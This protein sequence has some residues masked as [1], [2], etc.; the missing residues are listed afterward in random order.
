MTIFTFPADE[1]QY[2][3]Q[4]ARH[5]AYAGV[6]MPSW[7]CPCCNQPRRTAGRKRRVPISPRGGFICA[8]CHAKREARKAKLKEVK[9]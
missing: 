3:E 6:P 2:R 7:T 8:A 1:H 5:A 9:A 4:T